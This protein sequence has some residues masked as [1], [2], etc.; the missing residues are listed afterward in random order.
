MGNFTFITGGA[1]SGKSDLALR[2]AN[3]VEG[4][5]IFAA[6]ARVTDAE[7]KERIERHRRERGD[8]WETLE[9]P[10]ELVGLVR[11]LDPAARLLLIDCI[12]VWIANLIIERKWDDE[13]ILREVNELA[14]ALRAFPE[15]VIAVTNEV[16]SG[17]V[18]ESR[19][20]RRFRDLAG[21]AN[22][23][24]ASA[25]GRVYLVSM[26]IPLQLKGEKP[27]TNFTNKS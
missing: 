15:R 4:R 13:R 7:M 16:G 20:G 3:K 14:G 19:L 8:S 26:G 5:R 1:R 2:L 23:I 25:A 27:A 12:T 11:S 21:A 6:T 22:R 17:I 10:L 24:L 18:P 9:E